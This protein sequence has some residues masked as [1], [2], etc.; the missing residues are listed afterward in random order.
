MKRSVFSIFMLMILVMSM[1]CGVVNA[2]QI[3]NGMCDVYVDDKANLLT[4][5]EAQDLLNVVGEYWANYD[6]N[7]VLLT[8]S[9]SIEHFFSGLP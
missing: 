3:T 1:F 9:L 8:T 4:Q 6:V 2:S 7:V 5:T